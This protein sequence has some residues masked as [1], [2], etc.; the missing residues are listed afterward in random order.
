MTRKGILIAGGFTSLL[1]QVKTRIE[2]INRGG[3]YR[4]RSIGCRE[5]TR[6]QRGP[7]DSYGCTRFQPEPPSGETAETL[8]EKRYRMENIYKQEGL[9]GGQRVEVIDLMETTYS[10]QRTHINQMPASSIEH[11]RMKWP[12]LFTKRGIY[13]HFELLTDIKVLQ[14]LE[15]SMEDCGRAVVEYFR[16]KSNHRDVQAI[17]SQGLDGDLTLQVVQLLMAHFG[18]SPDGLMIHTDVSIHQL[19]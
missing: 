11:L 18:E 19:L 8:E 9:N 10:L 17:V 4:Q 5:G 2:N 16:T 3:L 15:L 1:Q 12:Y 13:A 14:V 6:P 7:T